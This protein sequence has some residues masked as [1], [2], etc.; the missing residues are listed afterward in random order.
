M[1]QY[2]TVFLSAAVCG[3]PMELLYIQSI[4]PIVKF[5]NVT[6]LSINT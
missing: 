3:T 2:V 4:I 6:D 1:K 5:S